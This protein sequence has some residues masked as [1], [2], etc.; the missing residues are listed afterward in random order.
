MGHLLY[1]EFGGIGHTSNPNYGLFQNIQSNHYWSKTAYG[2]YSTAAWNFGFNDGVQQGGGMDY[3]AFY[4]MA[5]RAG[6]VAAVPVPAAACL[7][8]SGLIG[9]AG[10]ARRR[11]TT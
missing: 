6:D 1:N 10:I 5:V 4:A 7:L 11:K 2:N 8:G 3:P 9:L